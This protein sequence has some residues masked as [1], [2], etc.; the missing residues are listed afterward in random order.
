[1]QLTTLSTLVSQCFALP[2]VRYPIQWVLLGPPGAG[3]G[4]YAKYL[5][6]WYDIAHISTGDLLRKE[7]EK[8]STVGQQ[9][10]NNCTRWGTYNCKL[11]V[12]LAGN[13]PK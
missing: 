6:R 7:I 12:F 9:V 1:M 13:V 4:T 10:S 8:G 2:T 3:K 11:D 5:A